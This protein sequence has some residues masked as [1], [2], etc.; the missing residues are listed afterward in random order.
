MSLRD[1][2]PLPL[3]PPLSRKRMCR[4]WGNAVIPTQA[5]IQ[6]LEIIVVS[7]SLD[8]CFRRHDELLFSL[9]GER[10]FVLNGF[11]ILSFY[12]SKFCSL[13]GPSYTN[14]FSL[15]PNTLKL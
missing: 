5:V 9:Q 8:A 2:I 15:S 13:W 10:R 11:L 3:T 4:N 7:N 1:T 12:I 14:D 6:V